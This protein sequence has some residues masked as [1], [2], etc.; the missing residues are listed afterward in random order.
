MILTKS[1]CLPLQPSYL[2]Q[3]SYLYC[4]EK[5]LPTF[6]ACVSDND[7]LH[8]TWHGNPLWD[9]R[10]CSWMRPLQTKIFRFDVC[11][12]RLAQ[13]WSVIPSPG[14][15]RVC[16]FHFLWNEFRYQRR[17]TI[18]ANYVKHFLVS[19]CPPMFRSVYTKSHSNSRNQTIR[20]FLSWY[21]KCIQS[22]PTRVYNPTRGS[23]LIPCFFQDLQI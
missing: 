1:W 22:N 9:F 19:T 8:I 20:L 13:S 3:P 10:K 18:S 6:R 17:I 4:K 16:V 15:W 5:L 23:K 7:I 12:S 14:L 2:R 11:V 21:T